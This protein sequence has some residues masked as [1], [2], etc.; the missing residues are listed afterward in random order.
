MAKSRRRRAVRVDS[1]RMRRRRV[2]NVAAVGEPP[3]G[4]GHLH[5]ERPAFAFTVERNA[6]FLWQGAS[7]WMKGV[8]RRGIQD[9][10]W[11]RN[12]PDSREIGQANLASVRLAPVRDGGQCTSFRLGS[13]AVP[14]IHGL[15]C[16]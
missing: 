6:E 9:A 11:S 5:Q 4:R 16:T 2:G 15:G 7:A 12:G 13:S 1:E 8:S 14:I 10:D 3:S